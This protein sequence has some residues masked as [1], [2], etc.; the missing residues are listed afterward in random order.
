LDNDHEDS[1]VT[2]EDLDMDDYKPGN[3]KS[4]IKGTVKRKRRRINRKYNPTPKVINNKIT[5]HEKKD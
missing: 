4:S 2:E 3:S 1:P 5:L